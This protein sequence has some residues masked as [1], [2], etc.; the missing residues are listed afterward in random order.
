MK[1]ATRLVPLPRVEKH[2]AA[3]TVVVVGVGGLG[4]EVA[5]LLAQAGVGRMI[6]CDPDTVEAS[7]LSRGALFLPAHVGLPKVDA[8]AQV[9]RELAPGMEVEVR[10]DD[11]RYGV[12]L[13]ELRAAD[14]VL[15]CLDS[16]ADRIA[17][18]SRCIFSGSPR[19]LLDAGL[20]PWGGEV[21]HYSSD[22]S[23]YVCGC[24]PVD[25]SMPAWHVACGFPPVLGAPA[26]VVTLVASWQ[27]MFAV[28]LLFDEPLPEG[29]VTVDAAA[30]LSRP[31]LQDR[32]EDCPCHE[33]IDHR[34]IA[35]TD[36]TVDST[37]EEVL[38]LTTAGERVQ[39]WNPVDRQ[40]ALSPLHLDAA[41]PQRRLRELGIP[42]AEFLPVLRARPSQ[43][44]RYLA[45]RGA[46]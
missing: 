43:H 41:G 46:L 32:A 1:G 24:S 37:V 22:G 4:T 30:G 45:L 11:F 6:L 19:G 42:P 10:A 44:V 7:N 16:I 35:T 21:R 20:H 2:L 13:G 5:R 40:D 29:I 38:A 18:S 8:A 27:A 14:L 36:L 9:L 34:Y 17:L 31:V 28:R 25:R 12:G 3:A 26:P 15:S 23:C 39:S 33:V